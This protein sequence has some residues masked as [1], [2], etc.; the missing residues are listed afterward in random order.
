[1]HKTLEGAIA[2]ACE[3]MLCRRA[4]ANRKVPG[5]LNEVA[6]VV[7]YELDNPRFSSIAELEDHF[8]D[9]FSPAG[10]RRLGEVTLE[11]FAASGR[12]T[13]ASVHRIHWRAP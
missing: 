5:C 3:E 6:V 1:M 8:S 4:V 7:S 13:G 9:F 12:T 10:Y 11:M 2:G